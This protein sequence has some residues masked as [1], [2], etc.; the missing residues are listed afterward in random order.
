[1]EDKQKHLEDSLHYLELWMSVLTTFIY[2]E[3]KSRL[4]SILSLVTNS[5]GLL[6]R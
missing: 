4:I 5:S 6:I 1:M 2:T 3:S